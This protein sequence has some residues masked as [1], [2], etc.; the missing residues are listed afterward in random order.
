MGTVRQER[1]P[2]VF[3]CSDWEDTGGLGLGQQKEKR[4]SV[5]NLPIFLQV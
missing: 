5:T 2:K 4:S 1:L 3:F